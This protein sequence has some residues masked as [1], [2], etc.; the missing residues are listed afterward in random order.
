[1]PKMNTKR[2]KELLRPLKNGKAQGISTEWKLRLIEA[3]EYVIEREKTDEDAREFDREFTW[4]DIG[5]GAKQL[6]RR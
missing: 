2:A 4:K 5:N 3:L 1:M 6:A